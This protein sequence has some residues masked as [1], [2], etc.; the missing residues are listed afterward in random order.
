[1]FPLAVKFLLWGF[2]AVNVVASFGVPVNEFDDA[3]PLVHGIL[4]QQGRTPH[5]DFS[6]FYPPLGLY[7][8]AASFHL[9]GRSVVATR[10]VN[11]VFYIMVLLLAGRFLRSRFPQFRVVVPAAVLVLAASI[12]AAVNLPVWP[13]FATSLAALLTYLCF[14]ADIDRRRY[15]LAASGVLTAV[16]F[17][18]RLNFGAY[19]AAVVVFDMLLQW[20]FAGQ[21]RGTPAHLKK[22][23][24]DL[25]IYAG[26]LVF[27]IAGFCLLLYGSNIAAA[28]SEFTVKTHTVMQQRG[29]MNFVFSANLTIALT[30]PA[31]WFVFRILEGEEVFPPKSL[32]PVAIALLLFGVAMAGRNRPVIVGI[33]VILQL[34]AVLFLH[35][36]VHRLERSE[37][38]VLAFSCC[39]FHYFISRADWS[40]WRVLPAVDAILL[41]FLVISRPE[42]ANS[43]GSS[44]S[45]GTSMAVLLAAAFLLLATVEYRPSPNHLR[46]GAKVIASLAAQPH[47]SDTDRL[48]GPDRELW[49]ALYPYA[50]ELRALH[51]VR[52]RTGS[53]DPIFVGVQDHSRVFYNNL[54]LYWL[55]GRPIGTRV[56]QLETRVAT[57]VAVQTK[58][59]EDLERNGVNWIIIDCQPVPGD[60]TFLAAAYVGSNLLDKY[61]ASH[62]RENARYGQY[63]VLTRTK[64]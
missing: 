64:T 2:V 11:A 12:G 45:K 4:V 3:I 17:L 51:Y 55:A 50:N 42:K 33:L 30:L 63:A 25:F 22:S 54:R 6:Y 28:V 62:Y 35:I 43:P 20:C 1:M 38:C 19:V 47:L 44:I 58:I 8:N 21:E 53:T 18:Y 16:A 23:L 37:F 5:L 52:E 29:F 60:E 48:F 56:F 7:L 10:V 49:A 31:C 59:I 46:S 36:V 15:I 14:L 9:L 26:P 41:S 61:I 32:I 39:V 13:G 57:E 34:G 27:C 40:H 24:R